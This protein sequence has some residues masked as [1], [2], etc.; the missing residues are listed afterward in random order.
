MVLQEAYA[1]EA[2][3][4]SKAESQLKTLQENARLDF[5]RIGV[6]SEENTELKVSDHM[7]LLHLSAVRT[8]V[9]CAVLA[10]FHG[11]YGLH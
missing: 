1:A 2:Q 10:K 4:R 3:A 5:E 11:G 6:L 9:Y 8:P 7:A